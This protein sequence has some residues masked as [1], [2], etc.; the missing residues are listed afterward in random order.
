M[1]TNAYKILMGKSLETQMITLRWILGTED[2]H[3]LVLATRKL[4]ILVAQCILRP[5]GQFIKR[6]SPTTVK[7]K[8]ISFQK[9]YF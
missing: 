1:T 3:V 2:T 8:F 4:L 7:C 6:K 9:V 5:T